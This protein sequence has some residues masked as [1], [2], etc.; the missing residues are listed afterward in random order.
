VQ[1]GKKGAWDGAVLR[2]K[3]EMWHW[4][5]RCGRLDLEKKSDNGVGAMVVASSRGGRRAGRIMCI[6]M[7]SFVGGGMKWVV[8]SVTVL[9]PK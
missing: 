1:T 4:Q 9:I 6:G 8:E 2:N 5:G 7:N 3:E